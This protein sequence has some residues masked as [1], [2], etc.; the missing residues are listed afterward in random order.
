MPSFEEQKKASLAEYT[1]TH[2][3]RF[4][5]TLNRNNSKHLGL[6][7]HLLCLNLYFKYIT[8]RQY[9]LLFP[10][11]EKNCI[12]VTLNRMIKKGGLSHMDDIP[13]YH[14]YSITEAGVNDIIERLPRL[15]ERC[16]PLPDDTTY[17][18]TTTEVLSF[19]KNRISSSSPV[20]WH[21]FFGIR[22]FYFTFLSSPLTCSDFL[23][24]QES[25]MESG[26]PLSI[27]QQFLTGSRTIGHE[28]TLR[29]DGLLLSQCPA[30]PYLDV[31]LHLEFDSGS[32]RSSV[33]VS[34]V[35]NYVANSSAFF[36]NYENS[37]GLKVHMPPSVIF[38]LS[39]K[40]AEKKQPV[41][42]KKLNK[43]KYISS[44]LRAAEIFDAISALPE[45]PEVVERVDTSLNTCIALFEHLASGLSGSTAADILPALIRYQIEYPSDATKPIRSILRSLDRCK[46]DLSA[47][48]EQRMNEYYLDY[49]RNRK[50][51]LWRRVMELDDTTFLPSLLSGLSIFTVSYELLP[52][53]LPY[54]VPELYWYSS[55]L[56][57]FL[58]DFGCYTDTFSLS[59]EHIGKLNGQYL[60]RNH[61]I[62]NDSDGI[63]HFYYENISDDL[64]GYLRI[65]NMLAL[66]N[67]H[68]HVARS[69]VVCITSESFLNEHWKEITDSNYYRNNSI[70]HSSKWVKE[71]FEILFCTPVDFESGRFFLLLPNGNRCYKIRS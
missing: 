65:K 55:S 46:S 6:P 13:T 56:I 42:V 18:F 30:Y 31:P 63:Y 71:C 11:K 51:L 59:Y 64:G 60:L 47:D 25:V 54:L 33:L 61:Y 41:P 22:D 49:Y 23:F 7:D 14:A 17:H 39:S 69:K 67:G 29:S 70:E 8:F 68:C 38:C 57:T 37:P 34:K 27:Y 62:A 36:R 5:A 44:L 19:L 12:Q 1:I 66:S 24:L 53:A 48:Y 58:S 4:L 32:Q 3:Q 21:H 9:Q 40:Y 35:Q 28:R 16:Y 10:L 43:R 52:E 26:R 45:P 50:N 15:F 2:Y 20:Y